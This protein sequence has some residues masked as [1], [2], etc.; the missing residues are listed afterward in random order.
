[1]ECNHP[2]ELWIGTADGIFCQKCGAKID[3]E[4]KAE[5]IEPKPKKAAPKKG[6]KTNAGK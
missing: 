2:R 5:A 4:P 3:L 1:M 6:G